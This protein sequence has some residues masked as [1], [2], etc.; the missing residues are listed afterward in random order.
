MLSSV[1]TFLGTIGPDFFLS[2][3]CKK[4]DGTLYG[5]NLK[6]YLLRYLYS[7]NN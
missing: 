5:T 6:K 3:L 7:G 4:Q 2:Y 1:I